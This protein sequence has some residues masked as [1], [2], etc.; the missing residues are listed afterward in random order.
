MKMELIAAL[1][2]T[3]RVLFLD[4]PTIG[5][6]V[7]SQKKCG[8][9]SASTTRAPDR[10]DA[11]EPLHAGYRGALPARDHHRSRRIFFDGPLSAI[12]DRF[13]TH[14]VLSLTFQEP[15]PVSLATSARSSKAQPDASPEGPAREGE[16][17]LP[18]LTD[19]LQ[20]HDINVQEPPIEE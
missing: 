1:I 4:E 16:R 14:K 12:M 8:S 15:L 17:R 3:P 19:H 5:L 10:D 20:D 6:D 9:F 2:H 11:H 13:A 18:R 7:T